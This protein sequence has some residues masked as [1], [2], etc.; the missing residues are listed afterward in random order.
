MDQIRI[1]GLRIYARHGVYEEERKLG[2]SFYVDARLDM[3]L[4]A[5]GE[6]DD[7]DFSADY[8]AVCKKIVEVMTGEDFRLIEAAAHRTAQEV[9]LSFPAVQSITLTLHKPQAPIALPFEDVAVRIKRGWHTAYVASGSNLGDREA[10]LRMG[11]DGLNAHPLCR[12]EQVAPVYETTPYGGVEQGEFLN[13]VMKVRTLL[14][15]DQLLRLLQETEN[16][17]GR[18]RKV[19]W[20]PRTLDLDLLLYDDR[21]LETPRLIVPHPDMENRDFVLK[22]LSDLAPGL[23]HP[24]SGQTIL[25][26]LRRLEKN[27]ELH[28][29][30]M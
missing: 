20:G 26:L 14:E 8:G 6:R 4:R 3:D 11:I 7:L 17:A 16:S 1:Q 28:V 18:E 10:F 5:A 27:G 21:I 29:K 2:Q 22:P 13:T 30:S 25:G 12:V 9:L 15:P 23:V 19:H 24:V